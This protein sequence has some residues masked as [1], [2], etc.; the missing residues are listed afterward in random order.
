MRV[1]SGDNVLIGGFI[2]SGADPK[3][4]VIRGIGPSLT[5]FGVPG[6]LERHNPGAIHRQYLSR[7]Q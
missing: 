5:P 6:A 1:Q 2:I 7:F 3:K 4:V